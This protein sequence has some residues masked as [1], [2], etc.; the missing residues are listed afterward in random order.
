ML[1]RTWWRVKGSVSCG[2]PYTGKRTRRR[3]NH[4]PV[5]GVITEMTSTM[6]CLPSTRQ[7]RTARDEQNS[8]VGEI[9]HDLTWLGPVRI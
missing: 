7:L 2:F 4:S 8:H 6:A 3:Q 1:A 9:D 5:M